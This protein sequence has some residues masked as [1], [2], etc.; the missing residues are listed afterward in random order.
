MATPKE[1]GDHNNNTAP[2]KVVEF[3]GEVQTN[4][5]KISELETP[6]PLPPRGDGP[7]NRPQENTRVKLQSVLQDLCSEDCKLEIFQED[8]SD[9]LIVSG[10]Y[11]EADVSG[12]TKKFNN[13]N[14]KDKTGVENAVSRWRQKSKLVLAS[15][16]LTGL[17]LA[18]LLVAGYYLKTHRKNSKGVRLAKSFQV[19]EE[20]QANTL[21]SVAPLPQEPLD[22]PTVNRQ[23]PPENGTDPSSTTNGHSDNVTPVAD[24]E[25]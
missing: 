18:S 2:E 21:V 4:L 22:K 7:A 14:I 8:R 6:A 25:M 9:E 17:L 11:V 1:A 15:L 5:A 23:S 10:N 13:D 24:T 16:L 20:N 3:I 12:M 19:D